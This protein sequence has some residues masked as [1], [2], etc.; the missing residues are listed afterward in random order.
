MGCSSVLRFR[1]DDGL[2]EA[3]QADQH[4]AQ[5]VP[6]AVELRG[7]VRWRAGR[8]PAASSQRPSSLEHEALVEPGAG[9]VRRAWRSRRCVVR[10]R[11]L[12][13]PACA[14]QVRP[15]GQRVGVVGPAPHHVVEHAPAP[16]SLRPEHQQTYGAATSAR[17]S[18]KR[19][20][21]SPPCPTC[22]THRS[23]LLEGD[24]GIHDQQQEEGH[25]RHV[26]VGH[27][28]GCDLADQQREGLAQRSAAVGRRSSARACAGQHEQHPWPARASRAMYSTSLQRCSE[29]ISMGDLDSAGATVSTGRLQLSDKPAQSTRK[30]D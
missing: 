9:V 30:P 19:F 23:D 26:A 2:V 24:H 3:L 6:G 22:A 13:R 15:A 29:S 16:R 11:G 20:I 8:P 18:R 21:G 12:C 27:L 28:P 4:Q 1:A 7:R 25:Q 14:Q 10:Q 17:G 5:A